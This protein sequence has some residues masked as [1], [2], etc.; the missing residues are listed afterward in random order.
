LNLFYK[1]EE[2]PSYGEGA[3]GEWCDEQRQ[4][5]EKQQMVDGVLERMATALENIAG[6]LGKIVL[7][8]ATETVAEGEDPK[9][10]AGRKGT[11]NGKETPVATTT[12]TA[13]AST[14]V[15]AAPTPAATNQVAS[16]TAPPKP[17]DVADHDKCKKLAGMILKASADADGLAATHEGDAL[18]TARSQHPLTVA[19]KKQ[20]NDTVQAVAGVTMIKDVTADKWAATAAAL[21][22]L[23]P[24][25][26]V[27][28]APEPDMAGV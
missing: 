27:A 26:V 2:I 19:N 7:N 15:A 16:T 25:T 4:Q 9:P 1:K 5:T 18:T 8:M 17:P 3:Y 23:T 10:R 12:P 24:I 14:A 11:T 6:S 20:I 28:A 21:E 13:T 22:K